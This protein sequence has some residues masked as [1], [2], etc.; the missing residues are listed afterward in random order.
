M[1]YTQQ[2][3]VAITKASTQK[4][5]DWK[6]TRISIASAA[7]KIA[8]QWNPAGIYEEYKVMETDAQLAAIQVV[9]NTWPVRPTGPWPASAGPI[10][11][12]K[13]EIAYADAVTAGCHSLRDEI[14]ESK[15]WDHSQMDFTI[16]S[17]GST[18][19]PSQ[20]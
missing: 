11:Q 13:D 2:H 12:R 3:K 18:M 9:R 19:Y 4:T 17:P 15:P 8:Q 20:T 1:L 14:I 16:P 5:L 7:K 10:A 6:L